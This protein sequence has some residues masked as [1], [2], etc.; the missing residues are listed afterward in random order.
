MDCLHSDFYDFL[1]EVAPIRLLHVKLHEKGVVL[2]LI[3]IFLNLYLR[4]INYIN[5]S[6]VKDICICLSAK[7]D[8]LPEN[9]QEV[10]FSETMNHGR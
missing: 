6:L 5:G 8:I 3:F 2:K 7:W 4:S 9:L 1:A 10:G